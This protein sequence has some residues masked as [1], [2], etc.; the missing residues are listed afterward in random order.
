LPIKQQQQ[1]K[2]K[3]N[4]TKPKNSTKNKQTKKKPKTITLLYNSN[5]Q[6]AWEKYI[7]I[8]GM[9]SPAMHR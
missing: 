2:T 7:C 9:L 4:K 8:N 3:Q 1:N 6:C 5:P